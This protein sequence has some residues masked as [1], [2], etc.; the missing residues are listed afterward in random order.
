MAPKKKNATSKP[1]RSTDKQNEN[2]L[3]PGGATGYVQAQDDEIE[4]LKAIYMNDYEDV[5]TKGAWNKTDRAFKLTLK[6]SSNEDIYAV[7]LVKFTATYPKTAPLISLDTT[8]NVRVITKEA[9]EKLLKS[10]IKDLIG[11]V[12]IYELAT[13]VQD[14]LEDEAQNKAHGQAMPSLEEERAKHE[15]AAINLAKQQEEEKIR[16]LNEAK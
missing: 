1:T 10:K 3:S 8:N 6:S 11:E 7:I 9:I 4:A 5:E 16:R 15:A 12:M 13:A 14:I 2:I